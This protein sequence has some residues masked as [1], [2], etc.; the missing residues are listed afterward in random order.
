MLK[1]RS[2]KTNPAPDVVK[3]RVQVVNLS[4]RLIEDYHQ[5]AASSSNC[6]RLCYWNANR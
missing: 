2:H 4:G 6:M 3:R 1:P 5:N